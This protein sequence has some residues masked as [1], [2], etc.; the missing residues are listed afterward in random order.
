MCW[1]TKDN[2]MKAPSKVQIKGVTSISSVKT[3]KWI[4]VIL[5]KLFTLVQG[6]ET[7]G[8]LSHESMISL[9]HL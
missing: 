3:F 4:K 1:A 2:Y 7:K 6:K 5:N 8:L 9:K